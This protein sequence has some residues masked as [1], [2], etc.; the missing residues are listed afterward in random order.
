MHHNNHMCNKITITRI[1]SRTSTPYTKHTHKEG[2]V[3]TLEVEDEDLVEEGVRLH[4]IT[5]DNWVTMPEIARILQ[6]HVHI[7]KDRTIMWRNVLS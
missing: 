6:R 2:V 5:V 1:T 3:E 4:A 7:V